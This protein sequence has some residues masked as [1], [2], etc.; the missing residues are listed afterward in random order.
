MKGECYGHVH[1]LQGVKF[2][3]NNFMELAPTKYYYCQIFPKY[4]N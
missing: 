4:G 1:V 2:H 3:V